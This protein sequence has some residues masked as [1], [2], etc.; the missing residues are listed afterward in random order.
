MEEHQSNI[1]NNCNTDLK[2]T[3]QFCSSCGQKNTTGK[4]SVKLLIYE[5]FANHL[6]LDSKL[7]KTL[8]V[9]FFKPGKLTTSYFKGKHITFIRPLRLF[10]VSAIIFFTLVAFSINKQLEHFRLYEQKH[11][12]I[13]ALEMTDSLYQQVLDSVSSVK[14]QTNKAIYPILDSAFAPMI[15]D[16]DS[17]L[18]DTINYV[19]LNIGPLKSEQVPITREDFFTLTEDEIVQKYQ[20]KGFWN[21]FV[22]KQNLRII[23]NTKGFSRQAMGNISWMLFLMVPVFALLLKLFYIRRKI[24]YVEHL[25]FTFHTHSFIFLLFALNAFLNNFMLENTQNIFNL[26]SIILAWVYLFIAMKHVYKQ[27]FIKTFFKMLLLFFGYFFIVI[28][29]L[30]LTLLVSLFLF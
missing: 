20:P 9:L 17:L 22:L 19:Y 28:S 3:D 24:Y 1:C 4:I 11:D 7:P 16:I 5:F 27:G 6:H 26:I 8:F 25:I 29:F 12:E 2:E 23:R 10:A 18:N 13:L 15:I 14:K 30:A 21:T